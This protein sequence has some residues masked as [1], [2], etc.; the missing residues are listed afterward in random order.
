MGGKHF[1]LFLLESFFFNR[2]VLKVRNKLFKS[3]HVKQN[4]IGSKLSRL[5]KLLDQVRHDKKISGPFL[6]GSSSDLNFGLST[7][8]NKGLRKTY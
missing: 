5:N 8:K 2:R 4:K 7:K 1:K 3:R 6:V